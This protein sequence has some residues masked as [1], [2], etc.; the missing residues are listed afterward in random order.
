MNCQHDFHWY[1]QD[2]NEDGWMCCACKHKPGEP[3]GF[4]PELDRKEIERKAWAI[5]HELCD[6][7]FIYVSNSTAGDSI[8]SHVAD[9]CRGAG[10]YDQWSVAKCILDTLA[11]SHGTF[12]KGISDG[13]IAGKDP[14]D[15]CHCGRLSNR[16]IGD[17]HFC[18]SE[19]EGQQALPW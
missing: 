4:S 19:C 6:A 14:R 17:R 2:C 10:F 9:M 11:P 3:P 8:S 7:K 1:L 13:I 16:S 12:W 5:L 18:S 15:R